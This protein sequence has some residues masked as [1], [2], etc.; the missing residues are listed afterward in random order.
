MRPSGSY[1]VIP[2]EEDAKCT[3]SPPWLRSV[4]PIVLDKVKS[5]RVCPEFCKSKFSNKASAK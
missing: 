4:T 5:H 1:L 3:T 2:R